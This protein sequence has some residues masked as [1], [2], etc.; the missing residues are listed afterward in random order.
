[1]EYTFSWGA[2]FVGII[3]LGLGTALT[4]WYRPIADNFGSG[5]ASYDRYRLV[6]LIGCVLG[7]LVMLNIH[8]L[9]LGVIFSQFFG[10]SI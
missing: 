8:A 3:I 9:L 1:M 5:V 7:V 10:S 6:G 2:F 4:L